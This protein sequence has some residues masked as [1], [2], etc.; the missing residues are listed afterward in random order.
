MVRGGARKVN[1]GPHRALPR[2]AAAEKP[3]ADAAGEWCR[4][5]RTGEH[6]DMAEFGALGLAVGLWIVL[7]QHRGA[8]GRRRDGTLVL[9]GWVLVA[10]S[11]VLVV[12]SG[13]PTDL[14][15]LTSTFNM[16]GTT[17]ASGAGTGAF[18]LHLLTGAEGAPP[19][20]AHRDRRASRECLTDLMHLSPVAGRGR[21]GF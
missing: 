14:T 21:G 3:S 2:R 5:P 9:L 16:D 6:G 15:G 7:A 8:R 11:A 20:A 12:T 4:P 13:F 10:V 18:N 19:T 17:T 1:G